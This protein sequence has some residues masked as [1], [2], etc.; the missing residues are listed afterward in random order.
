VKAPISLTTPVAFLTPF[1]AVAVF[2]NGPGHSLH[3]FSLA[4]LFLLTWLSVSLLHLNLSHF[5]TAWGWLP[6]LAIAYLGW[7]GIAPFI[8]TYPYATW[9]QAAGLAVLPL[10]FCGWLI[11]AAENSERSWAFTWRCLMFCALILAAWGI[12]DFLVLR[13]RAH[14]PLIDTNAYGAIINLFLIPVA[15]DYLKIPDSARGWWNPRLLLAAIV[16]LALA[17]SMTESRG[18]LLAFIAVFPLLLWFSRSSPVFRARLPWLVLSLVAAY[19]VARLAPAEAGRLGIEELA[20]DPG[21]RIVNDPSIQGRILM[22]KSAISMMADSNILIG[23]GIGTFVTHYPAYRDPDETSVGSFVHNDYLQ[24]LVEG[25]VVQLLFFLALTVVAPTW[26]LWKSR[27]VMTDLHAE[28]GP[29]TAQGLL[30][31]VVC[32]SLHALINFIHFIVPIAFLTGLYLAR[33]WE[34]LRPR[35]DFCIPQKM[36]KHVK[37]VF[38]KGLVIA[39]LAVP[40]A[41]LA[42]DGIIFKIFASDAVDH[43]PP[44]YRYAVLNSALAVR[45]G[46]PFP[47]IALIRHLVDSAEKTS[48][49]DSREK[50]LEQ[51]EKET[52]ALSAIAPSAA[53]VQFYQGKIL[54]IRGTLSSRLESKD[55]LER[56]VK[57]APQSATMRLELIKVYR[58]LGWE[59]EAYKLVTDAKRWIRFET[60]LSSRT[61]FVREAYAAALNQKDQ[62]EAEYWGRIQS[63]SPSATH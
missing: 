4:S 56:A 25:G 10:T 43:I 49:P 37:P 41:A 20:L 19:A 35:R 54:V 40:V 53:L 9:T 57:Q 60:S 50:L 28:R 11:Q 34:V 22:L 6:A 13:Q 5:R 1:F 39:A 12:T 52:R 44:R 21:Q 14:G 63:G 46:N 58:L 24:A 48:S 59:Y 3:W 42:M 16:L 33:A 31:G 47:R 61:A 62:D 55:Y 18:A 29:E 38:I 15:F 8:S 36:A 27:R 17:L 45:P 7:L 26:F 2:Y 32:I 30:I 51:A 23:R